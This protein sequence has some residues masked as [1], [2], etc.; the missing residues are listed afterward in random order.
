MWHYIQINKWYQTKA[1]TKKTQSF[2]I[3]GH[4]ILIY[5]FT[6]IDAPDIDV[7]EKSF[8][9]LKVWSFSTRV[10]SKERKTS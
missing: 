7:H 1:L 3:K 2:V 10:S 9:R 6:A 4:G 5:N 8:I